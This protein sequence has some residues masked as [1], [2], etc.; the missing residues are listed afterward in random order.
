VSKCDG[1]KNS[2]LNVFKEFNISDNI[3]LLNTISNITISILFFVFK[4]SFFTF[5]YLSSLRYLK[6]FNF[7]KYG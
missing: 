3:S 1:N 7:I 5:I 4:F 6:G 2:F